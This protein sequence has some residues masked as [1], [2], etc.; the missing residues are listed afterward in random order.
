MGFQLFLHTLDC[1]ILRYVTLQD[2]K[3][4][5]DESRSSVRSSCAR[6]VQ[7]NDEQR[8]STLI[9]VLGT[10]NSRNGTDFAPVAT[11]SGRRVKREK[12]NQNQSAARPERGAYINKQHKRNKLRLVSHFQARWC[13]RWAAV[14]KG[15]G[16]ISWQCYPVRICSTLRVRRMRKT[17]LSSIFSHQFKTRARHLQCEMFLLRYKTTKIGRTFPP[18]INSMPAIQRLKFHL[19]SRHYLIRLIMMTIYSGVWNIW[20][21]VFDVHNKCTH[22]FIYSARLV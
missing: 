20:S 11:A 17:A 2:S 9:G 6:V 12:S 14:V 3:V 10:K 13:N 15:N 8:A 19:S 5:T 18:F 7:G 16:I 21:H 1:H 22:I 4:A